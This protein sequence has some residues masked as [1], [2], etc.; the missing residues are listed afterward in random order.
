MGPGITVQ[1]SE[2]SGEGIEEGITVLPAQVSVKRRVAFTLDSR[3]WPG[4]AAKSRLILAAAESCREVVRSQREIHGVS[5]RLLV[6]WP[7]E[8][9]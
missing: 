2:E 1:P 7:V 8:L 3:R 5:E 6:R 4:V 9:R